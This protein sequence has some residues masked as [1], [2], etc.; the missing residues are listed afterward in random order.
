MLS[1]N[2]TEQQQQQQIV[3]WKGH[4]RVDTQSSIKQK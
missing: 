1:F 4:G 3:V 2:Q